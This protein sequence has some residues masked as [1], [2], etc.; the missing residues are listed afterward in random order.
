MPARLPRVHCELG[1]VLVNRTAVYQMCRAA[2]AALAARGFRVHASA[3][4]AR[5]GPDAEPDGPRERRRFDRSR[6]WLE[7]AVSNPYA[8]LRRRRLAG[9][10]PRLRHARGLS[11]FLDPLYPL[12]FGG[13]SRGVVLSYDVTPATDPAWHP[14]AVGVLYEAAYAHLARSGFHFVTSCH[15]TADHLRVNWGVAPSRI[16][17]LHLGLFSLP[18]PPAAAGGPP[19]EPF[20]LFVGSIEPRK[21]VEGLI[22]A[23]DAAGVYASH[24]LRLRLCG[25]AQPEG[26][27]VMRLARETPGVDVRGFVSPEEL[28]AGYSD[29]AGFVYPSFCEGFGLPLLEAMHR[30]CLCLSTLTGASPEVGGD[31]VLYVNPYDPAEVAAGLRRLVELSPAERRRLQERARRRAATFTWARFYDGLADVLRRAA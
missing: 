2:P 30:G 24:G 26:H 27:P 23:Y 8:F 17:V 6:R 25:F 4:L 13:L 1:P 3:L 19:P 20:L 11:L 18:E 16:T 12:F 5:L 7:W 9:L 14:A 15:N 31:A 10:A 21:N 29:C 22:R 28:A